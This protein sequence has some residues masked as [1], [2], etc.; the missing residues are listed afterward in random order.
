MTRIDK[1]TRLVKTSAMI[2]ATN[3]ML[4]D[5]HE[6]TIISTGTYIGLIDLEL[7]LT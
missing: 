2:Y 5:A 4:L 7:L 1:Y 3:Y 6:L